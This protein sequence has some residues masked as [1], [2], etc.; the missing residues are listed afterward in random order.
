[1][2]KNNYILLIIIF[3]LQALMLS[4]QKIV[5]VDYLAGKPAVGEGDSVEVVYELPIDKVRSDYQLTYRPV[6]TSKHSDTL[7][8][9]PVV[10]H[11]SAYIRQAHRDFVLNAPKGATEQTYHR[12]KDVRSPLRDTLRVELKGHEWLLTDTICMCYT[13]REKEG[14]CKLTDMG[15]QCGPVFAFAEPIVIPTETIPLVPLDT[16]KDTVIPFVHERYMPKAVAGLTVQKQVPEVIKRINSGA[17]RSLE[18]YR[19][20]TSTEILAKDSDALLVYFELDKIQLKEEFRDNQVILDSIV[21]LVGE[22]LAD[23]TVEVKLVQIV[24]L[25]SAEGPVEHNVWLAGERAKALE[26]YIR[27]RYPDMTDDMFETNNG[28]EAWTELRYQVEQSQPFDGRD[29]ILSII[30]NTADVNL[31]ERQIKALH[32][33][34]PYKYILNNILLDQRNSGYIRIYYDVTD[35]EA[36]LINMSIRRMQDASS[37]DDEAQKQALLDEALTM[38]E[39]VKRDPRS[40]NTMGVALW[41]RGDMAATDEERQATRREATEWFRRAADRGDKEAKRNLEMMRE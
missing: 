31:R 41:L 9:E 13:T 19:P 3:C 10:L 14:C 38:L 30:D 23:S 7:A 29:E 18:D 36:R 8:L 25:A 32:G 21:R 40:W 17:L 1:M 16:A 27:V 26:A 22:L 15:G 6:I 37:T 28:G 11:G 4:A 24:G 33:G 20:Y 34:V 2:S 35:D 5:S 12:M 39:L